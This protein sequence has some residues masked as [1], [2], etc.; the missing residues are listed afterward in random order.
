[1]DVYRVAAVNPNQVQGDAE[2]DLLCEAQDHIVLPQGH[3]FP[4]KFVQPS[5]ISDLTV[6]LPNN[7]EAHLE[8]RYGTDWRT[9][10]HSKGWEPFPM[11]EKFSRLCCTPPLKAGQCWTG[12]QAQFNN[13]ETSG[14]SAWKAEQTK[15]NNQASAL[16]N[17]TSVQMRSTGHFLKSLLPSGAP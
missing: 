10:K 2:T 14:Y 17:V 9:P 4:A 12:D 11:E 7:P 6:P 8:S 1:V 15:S 13:W 16:L 3:L 5:G